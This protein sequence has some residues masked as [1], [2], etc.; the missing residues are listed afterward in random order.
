MQPKS[1]P[2]AKGL[3]AQIERP[4]A[5]QSYYSFVVLESG[6]NA[7]KLVVLGA[8]QV[9]VDVED[10]RSART[11]RIFQRRLVLNKSA[12]PLS[13]VDQARGELGPSTRQRQVIRVEVKQLQHQRL[14]K[15]RIL[16][17]KRHCLFWLIS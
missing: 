1:K 4:Y 12:C 6:K 15:K 3:C 11:P 17:G 2:G 9:F 13:K 5:R 10:R 16:A 14:T 7:P 8:P